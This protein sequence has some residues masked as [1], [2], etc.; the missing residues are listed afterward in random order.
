[1]DASPLRRPFHR[2]IDNELDDDTFSIGSPLRPERSDGSDGATME[3]RSPH[4]RPMPPS[5]SEFKSPPPPIVSRR[6]ARVDK[7]ERQ[8]TNVLD[9]EAVE[10][11]DL[12]T[13]A[14]RTR[15]Q[16]ESGIQVSIDSDHGSCL[17]RVASLT[18]SSMKRDSSFSDDASCA[19]ALLQASEARSVSQASLFSLRSS[20]L[21]SRR[22]GSADTPPSAPDAFEAGETLVK[23]PAPKRSRCDTFIRPTA[24]SRGSCAL[25][26]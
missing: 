11:F 4:T 22:E 20:Q 7:R 26:L 9:C 6:M 16:H 24:L 2:T 3:L 14:P 15:A 10:F 19:N 25:R 23:C 18:Q 1:V 21:G 8:A 17:T 12:A 5:L 13:L